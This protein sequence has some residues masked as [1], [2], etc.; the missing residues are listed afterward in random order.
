MRYRKLS[1]DG[2]YT[3]GTGADFYVDSPEAVAQA[4]L[5]RL[6]LWRGEWFV[7]TRDG[8]PWMEEILGK[9][10]RTRSPDA[11]IKQRILGTEGVTEILSYSSSFDGNTRRMKVDAT[12][13]TRYGQ[14]RI[15]ETL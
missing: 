13:A 14:T 12:I 8:T 11:A 3:I 10:V 2:D 15:T 5:T 9:R 6:R 7:D 1:P 4:V